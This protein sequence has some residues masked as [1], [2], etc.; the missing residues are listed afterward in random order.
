VSH[1]NLARRAQNAVCVNGVGHDGD[2]PNDASYDVSDHTF[3][4]LMLAGRSSQNENPAQVCFARPAPPISKPMNR[5]A[6]C[7]DPRGRHRLK[8]RKDDKGRNGPV[9]QIG[10]EGLAA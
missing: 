5:F 8:D 3:R 10:P 7:C 4:T 2:S 1:T 6:V 9:V